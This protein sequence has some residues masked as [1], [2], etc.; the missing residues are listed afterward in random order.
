LGQRWE[1]VSQAAA[2][3]NSEPVFA[4]DAEKLYVQNTID[5]SDETVEREVEQSDSLLQLVTRLGRFS[6][7]EPTGLVLTHPVDGVNLTVNG[8]SS[9]IELGLGYSGFINKEFSRLSMSLEDSI[10]AEDDQVYFGPARLV[11]RGTLAFPNLIAGQNLSLAFAFQQ[12]LRDSDEVIQD[13]TTPDNRSNSGG[14]LDTQYAI[15]HL[16][17]SVPGVGSLFYGIDYIFNTGRTIGLLV[18]NSVDAGE[19]YQYKPVRAHL[20]RGNLSY[21][22]SDFFSSAARVGVTY[23]SG[24]EDYQ[25]FV[26][27]NTSGQAT[28]FTAATPAGTG[29]VFGLQSGN[30]T[31]AEVSWGMRPFSG[32]GGLIET[33]FARA[34]LYTYFRSTAEGPVSAATVDA[35]SSGSYLGNELD[36]DFR[37]RPFSDLGVG[38]TTGFLFANDDVLVAG[39]DSFEYV[40]RLNASLSF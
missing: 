3:F 17:G 34:A 21:F 23:S 18:D 36:L 16:D 30:S 27:G 22:M 13:G 39:S 32:D 5:F 31:I 35:G 25:S 19:S 15:V 8:V 28:M 12:D 7:T 14:L 33:L 2:T 6:L 38:L 4:V 24:D 9:R 20:V 29:A 11:G 1:F 37:W 40:I 10:D 26:E